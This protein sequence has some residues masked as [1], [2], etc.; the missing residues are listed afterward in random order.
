MK[1]LNQLYLQQSCLSQ[2]TPQV[3]ML[4][5]NG[6]DGWEICKLFQ[7]LGIS[8]WTWYVTF[9]SLWDWAAFFSVCTYTHQTNDGEAST[10]CFHQETV[11]SIDGR[12]SD[13][14]HA[15]MD[16]SGGILIL[17]AMFFLL[18]VAK[19]VYSRIVILIWTSP[20]LTTLLCLRRSRLAYFI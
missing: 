1:W 2:I 8:R 12:V 17:H 14:Q 13:L 15:N 4:Q 5:G 16:T 10:K 11:W 20:P 3:P 19:S 18:V 7:N 9:L 6:N